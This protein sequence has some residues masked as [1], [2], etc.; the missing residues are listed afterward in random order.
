V[1][2]AA[3]ALLC[4]SS[5]SAGAAPPRADVVTM[6]NGDRMTGEIQRLYEGHLQ[7]GTDHVGTLQFEWPSIQSV[8]S[9]KFF[10]VTLVDGRRLFGSLHAVPGRKLD[11]VGAAT[12]RVELSAIVQ[13]A[14]LERSF[15]KQLDG[16]ASVGISFS[17]SNETATLTASADVEYLTRLYQVAAT[18]SSY[19]DAQKGADTDTRNVVGLTLGRLLASRWRLVELNELFQS[20]QLGIRLRTTFGLAVDHEVV[21]TNRNLLSPTVGV[22]YSH[23]AYDGATPARDEVLART[24]LRYAFFTF[25]R[26]RTTLSTTLYVLPSLSDWGHLRLDFAAR[27]RV[28][29]FGDFYWS[30]DVYE[31]YDNRPPPGDSENDFGGSASLA[32]SF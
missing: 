28:K 22:A 17:Q 14:P 18:A 26:H 20:D 3:L 27:A 6:T 29:L 19:L 1:G 32:L 5:S 10:E 21:H 25:G 16:S 31:N 24:G 7:L 2:A 9:A 23:T 15:W 8:E 12:E 11:I 4:L 30:L 13:I